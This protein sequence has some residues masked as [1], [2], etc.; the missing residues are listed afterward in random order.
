MAKH[1]RKVSGGGIAWH[2]GIFTRASALDPVELLDA[3]VDIAWTRLLPK[4]PERPSLEIKQE[5]GWIVFRLQA[6][7]PDQILA[8]AAREKTGRETVPKRP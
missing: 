3:A 1:L 8:Q 6:V 4:S 5:R 2:R 7:S